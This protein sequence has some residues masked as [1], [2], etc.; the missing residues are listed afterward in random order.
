MRLT[1]DG[2]V[3]A[4]RKPTKAASDIAAVV[5]LVVYLLVTMLVGAAL[6]HIATMPQGGSL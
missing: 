4:S 6:A 3:E 2:S 5:R 1:G